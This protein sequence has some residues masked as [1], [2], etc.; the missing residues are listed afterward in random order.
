LGFSLGP[1]EAGGLLIQQ[2]LPEGPA[3]RAGLQVGDRLLAV[4]GRGIRDR[5][6]YDR[7]AS[8]FRRNTP[9]S[10]TLERSGVRFEQTVYPGMP[11]PA[12]TFALNVLTVGLYFLLTGI[13]ALRFH[14]DVRGR[15][16]WAFSLAVAA[17]FA[18]P[19]EAV[20]TTWVGKSA[21][22]AFTLLTGLQMGLDL[23]LASLI[24]DRPPWLQRMSRIV[25][26]YYAAGALFALQAAL[27]LFWEEFLEQPF[28]WSQE[29]SEHLLFN[30]GLPFWALAISVLLATRFVT[31]P[32]RTGR[33]QAG[34]VLLGQLPWAA[35]V[36]W[37]A[38]YDLLGL[39]RPVVPENVWP[40]VGIT[41]PIAVF[42]AIFRHHLFDLERVVRRALVYGS[43]TTVLVLAFYAAI[44]AGGLLF[45]GVVD[46]ES[47]QPSLWLVSGAT[48]LLGLLFNPLRQRL[49]A[50][51]D[52]RFF[53]ERSQLRRQVIELASELPAQGKLARMGEH[54]TQEIG[55]I[56]MAQ[57]ATVWLAAAKGGQLLSLA[58]TRPSSG[59]LE[60]THLI[61]PE[62]PGLRFLA[63][64]GRPCEVK[65]LLDRGTSLAKRL[66]EENATWLVPLVVQDRLLGVILIGPRVDGRPYTAEE[67]ELLE[68]LAQ[69]AA[70]VLENARLFDSATYES[71]TGLYRREAIL[72]VLDREWSRA[73]RYDR[74]LSVVLVDLDRFKEINDRY[75]HLAGDAVLQRLAH[76][77]KSVLRD[78]DFIGRYGGEEFLIVLPETPLAGARQFAE[79]IR[80]YISKIEIPLE[81]G[82]SIRL[83]LSA[84]IAGRESV[85]GALRAR[86]L[87]AAADEALYA[88]K[89]R[90]RN[91]VEAASVEIQ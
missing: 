62:D 10:L 43:L 83:T 24:P 22:L 13:A 59:E 14:L 72:E 82:V 17:E 12:W 5:K 33:M 73:Q 74:P 1:A 3:A 64:N 44:G 40:L 87:L 11:F 63:Q 65:Q 30:I 32:E 51:I 2:V 34:T 15:L 41:Y 88:A 37:V 89:H 79:K 29:A 53:P 75:G 66:R 4:N 71:L 49:E 50:W 47:S 57:S 54:L 7:A 26:G 91:R 68:L 18:L 16:L 23:H 76:E 90:G 67:L 39:P 58:T 45:A 6:E 84:G 46:A 21:A 19:N 52:E 20:L 8:A 48:L 31:Y 36:V 61:A 25:Q 70:T 56:F 60:M 78:S 86:A 81:S 55:R 38:S 28:W 85:P 80:D 35:L 77:L 27:P 69:H 9:Q 42:V